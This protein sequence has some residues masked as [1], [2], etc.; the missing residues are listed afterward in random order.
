MNSWD[1]DT[2]NSL[3]VVPLDP[4]GSIGDLDVKYV[5]LEQPEETTVHLYHSQK[6]GKWN[7]R[8]ITLRSDGQVVM[9]KKPDSKDAVNI[10][11]ISDF[12]IYSATKRQ[13][14]KVLKPPKKH[15][16]AVKSQ[17]RSSMFLST[18]N[19]VHFF[20]TDD[21]KLAQQWYKAVQGWRSWYLVTKMGEGQKKKKKKTA[22]KDGE[23]A[24]RTRQTSLSKD[25]SSIQ[26]M[27]LP[28]MDDRPYKIGSFQPLFNAE[29]FQHELEAPGSF[30]NDPTAT[31]SMHQRNMSLRSRQPPPSSFPKMLSKAG[32][33]RDSS[34]QST[35]PLES[36]NDGAFSPTSL[37]G[38]TYSLRQKAQKEREM[39]E[40]SEG[41]FVLGQNLLNSEIGRTSGDEGAATG[42]TMSMRSTKDSHGLKRGS[43]QR[44]KPK[45]LVD[46]TPEYKEPPQHQRRGRGVLPDQIP[47]GG[48]VNI[49]TSPEVAI[50]IPPSTAWRRPHQ[51]P[52][53]Y[54]KPF[55]FAESRDTGEEMFQGL[56]A[57]Q[58]R[59]SQGGTGRGKGIM[60]GDRYAREPMIDI[61]ERSRFAPG[62]LLAKV[63]HE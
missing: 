49:A 43:S 59:P 13:L 44:V 40:K 29:D 57:A 37:L 2:Q 63:G 46:L 15:C 52:P 21:K 24:S 41:A 36:G 1:R 10:C 11:H 50:P 8:F 34:E 55:A 54:Q 23:S 22:E 45:P 61:S 31:R 48:L 17:Q 38:R 33:S 53:I 28:S 60:T 58:S 25:G 18:E 3:S 56:L 30:T 5:S 62:S 51:S 12:D 35:L 42:R 6:P 9:G 19:F 27:R 26:H 32:H 20:S 16:Y 47:V 39:R 4:D 14:S 7:K